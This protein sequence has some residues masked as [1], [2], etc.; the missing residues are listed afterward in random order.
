MTKKTVVGV[1]GPNYENCNDAIF[2]FGIKLGKTLADMNV[3]IVTG[4]RKGIM[5]AIFKGAHQ[6]ANYQNPTTIG[7]LPSGN[8]DEA[9]AYCDIVIPTGIG[10][11]RN[12]IVVNTADILIAV[13]GG[14]GTLS[15]IAFAWQFNKKVICY[16]GFDGWAK[17]LA[18]L[19]L[20]TR[21]TGLL[22]KADSINQI[23]ELIKANC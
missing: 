21:N 19:N 3:L 17:N 15:E 11:A 16:T 13:A 5:E 6:S 12:S 20:D 1:I 2:A 7:I 9:N 4:G 22:L 10:L 18:G 8:K 14:S 23:T